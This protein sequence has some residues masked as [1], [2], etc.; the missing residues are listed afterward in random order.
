MTGGHSPGLHGGRRRKPIYSKVDNIVLEGIVSDA[1]RFSQAKGFIMPFKPEK[2]RFLDDSSGEDRIG[3]FEKVSSIV[4]KSGWRSTV[5]LPIYNGDRV[6][7]YG[8]REK[9]EDEVELHII[10]LLDKQGRV[11][12]IYTK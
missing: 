3:E 8:Y 9:D 6:R 5:V 12:A 1:P 10:E 7:V 11:K 4:F 2:A